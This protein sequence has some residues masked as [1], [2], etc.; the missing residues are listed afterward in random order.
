MVQG[1]KSLISFINALNSLFEQGMK[2]TFLT[3]DDEKGFCSQEINDF[4]NSNG[5][6]WQLVER[7]FD[8]CVFTI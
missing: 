6:T 7:K 4:L 1:Q 8:G 5:I 2:P 3:G